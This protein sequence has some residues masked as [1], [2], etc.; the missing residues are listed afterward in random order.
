MEGSSIENHFYYASVLNSKMV[1]FE[2]NADEKEFLKTI[3]YVIERGQ[4]ILDDE[5]MII[6]EK[7]K[8]FFYI[9]PNTLLAPIQKRLTMAQIQSFGHQNRLSP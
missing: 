3:N 1:H 8:T 4:E 5:K 2:N 6:G 9:G 7:A